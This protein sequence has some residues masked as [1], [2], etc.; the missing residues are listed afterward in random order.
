MDSGSL[1]TIAPLSAFEGIDLGEPEGTIPELAFAKWRLF[2]V[3]VIRLSM[4]VVGPKPWRDIPLPEIPV[5]VADADLPF[6]V[7]GSTVLAHIVVLIRDAEQ[8]VHIKPLAEFQ[9]AKH[10]DDETF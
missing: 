2:D 1:H 5:V 9:S 7:L 6:L 4:C 3:P 10:F 8:L